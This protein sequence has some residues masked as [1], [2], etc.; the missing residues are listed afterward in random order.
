M[1]KQML[2]AAALCVALA[3]A[4]AHADASDRPGAP[5]HEIFAQEVQPSVGGM[6]DPGAVTP[7]SLNGGMAIHLKMTKASAMAMDHMMKEHPA[8]GC[9]IEHYVP[10]ATFVM[11]LVCR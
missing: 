3:P 11:I 10:G 2:G 5:M 4:L 6:Q 7:Q 9:R 1:F 8:M